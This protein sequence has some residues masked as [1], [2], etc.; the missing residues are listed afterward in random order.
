MPKLLFFVEKT[1]PILREIIPPVMDFNDLELRETIKDMCYSIL[2]T[3]LKNA[4]G[5][6]ESAAGMAANQW[7][8]KRRVFIFTPQG[9]EEEKKLEVMINPLYV[10][11]LRPNET[12]PK[13]VAAYE[14]CFSIPLTAG[15]VNRYEAITATYYNLE[16]EKIEHM[17]EGW[18]ARVFQHETDHLNGKLFDGRLDNYSGPEC[19]ERILFKDTEEMKNYWINTVKASRRNE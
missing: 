1:H 9:S 19:L 18:E 7:G 3:Q 2:P 4:N 5:V 13:M 6:H 15:I 8:I 16:G 11:Y 12:E 17:M 10:P 14:G